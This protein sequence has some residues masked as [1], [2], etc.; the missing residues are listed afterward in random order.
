MIQNLIG[1]T[2][3]NVIALPLAAGILAP[4]G[5]YS[6]SGSGRGLDVTQYAHC[7]R[8]QRAIAAQSHDQVLS[9]G[10]TVT[11]SLKLR[12]TAGLAAI[13]ANRA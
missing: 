11:Y 12:E 8:A 7:G 6:L 5:I 10:T 2:G 3:Y 13:F 9:F 4:V 1:Q